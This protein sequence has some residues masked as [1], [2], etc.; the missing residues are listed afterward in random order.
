MSLLHVSA[1]VIVRE[2][3]VLVCQRP[4]HGH[5]PGKWEFPG[6]KLEPGETAAEALRRE[7]AEELDIE[8]LIGP[9]LWRSRHRYPGR[10]PFQ[11]TFFLVPSFRGEIACRAFSRIGW[12]S[13]GQLHEFDFLEG[14]LA[15]VAAVDRGEI[16]LPGPDHLFWRSDRTGE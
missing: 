1:G 2:G 3:R 16:D 5:H 12:V 7:L 10:G 4:P 15:F 11:L 8:A 9:E 6:G 14:D 13:V